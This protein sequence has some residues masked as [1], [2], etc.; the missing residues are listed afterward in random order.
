MQQWLKRIRSALVV[1]L[2]WGG[3][4]AIVGG[5]IEREDRLQVRVVI[6][7]LGEHAVAVRQVARRDEPVGVDL[8]DERDGWKRHQLTEGTLS[9]VGENRAVLTPDA[10]PARRESSKRRTV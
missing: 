7:D 3:L 2:V 9:S 6:G 8:P 1:G 5:G 4:L 10:Q